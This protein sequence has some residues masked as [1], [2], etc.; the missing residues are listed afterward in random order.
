MTE[1]NKDMSEVRTDMDNKKEYD[2]LCIGEMLAD[3]IVSGVKSVHFDAF[4]ERTD[5]IRI[6]PGGDAF[7]NAIDMARLGNSVCCAGR[8]STDVIGQSLLQAGTDAGVDMSH[9]IPTGTPQAKM[10]ILITS[11]DKRAFFYYPGTSAELVPEDIDLSLLER[12]RLLQIGSTFHLTGFDGEGACGILREAGKRGVITSMDVTSDFSGKWDKIIHCC[13]PYLDYFL[14]SI[15]QAEK[16]T[17]TSDEREI[18]SYLLGEGVR[19][20]VVKLGSRGSY[21]RNQ[22]E[23]FWC[24]VCDVPVVDSTGAGDAFVSGFLTG[25]LHGMSHQEAAR[26][27]TVCS[28][29]VIQSV[30]ANAGMPSMEEA[31]A[32][33]RTNLPVI[34]FRKP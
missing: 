14:P 24:G 2:I 32:C 12:C 22:K 29:G 31:A 28:A 1:E 10:T 7:N 18:A 16:I 5:E 25:V 20:V 26:L 9:V 13:Y 23:E 4:A 34:S 15:E 8:I 11:D 3:I 33:L 27:G 19:N 6:R 30:G 21:F 17:G